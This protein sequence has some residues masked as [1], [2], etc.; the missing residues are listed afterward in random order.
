MN[1]EKEIIEILNNL[2][3]YLNGDGGDCEFIKYEDGYVYIKLYGACAACQFKDYTI[4]DGILEAIQEKV[5]SCKGVINVE[6]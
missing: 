3:P 2:R 1:D 6:L 5:P 4:Q